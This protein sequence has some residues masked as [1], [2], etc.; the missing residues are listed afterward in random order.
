YDHYRDLHAVPTRRSS[1]LGPNDQLSRAAAKLL[2]KPGE[3]RD[4]LTQGAYWTGDPQDSLGLVEHTLRLV[5][6]AEPLEHKLAQALKMKINE[7]NYEEALA[8]GLERNLI[9]PAQAETIRHAMEAVRQVIQVDEFPP[10]PS[11][12]R[13]N[14]C[15]RSDLSDAR[16]HNS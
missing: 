2:Q 5:L 10:R 7:T 11:D 13:W 16:S 4:R 9:Q 15:N 14:P 8:Q 12:A 3:S 6:Q 1:D